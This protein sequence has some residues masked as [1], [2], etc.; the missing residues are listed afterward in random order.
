EVKAAQ[1]TLDEHPLD[2]DA[3]LAVGRYRAFMKV[4]W[5]HGVP[6]LALGSDSKLKELA[7]AELE[8]DGELDATKRPDEQLKLADA[9]WEYAGI[10]EGAARDRVESRALLWYATAL[11]QLSGLQKLRVEKLLQ[12]VSGRLY[13]KIQNAIRTKKVSRDRGGGSNHGSAFVD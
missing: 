3:N 10:H 5:D 2:A 4:D 12:E 11:P 6:M 1:A 8:A 9:W 7:T 13:A